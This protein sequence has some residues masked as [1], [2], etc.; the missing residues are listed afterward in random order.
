M[1]ESEGHPD[2]PDAAA[3][4]KKKKKSI[5]TISLFGGVMVV[6]GLAIFL[7]MKFLGTAP[8]PTQGL[9][10]PVPTTQPWAESS[11]LDVANLR[12]LNTMGPRTVLY[13]VR[14]VITVHQA[15]EEEIGKFLDSRKSTIEDALSRV[16]RGAEERHLAEPGLETLRR[17]LLF[18]LKKILGDETTIEHLLIPEFTQLPTGY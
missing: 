17:Q 18:E 4:G 13:H 15:N 6:E 16:V 5:I 10:Q 9:E 8:D 12:V 14:V 1:A 2:A 7:C 3:S 11:E